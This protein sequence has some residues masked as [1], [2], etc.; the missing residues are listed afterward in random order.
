M[1]EAILKVEIVETR[2]VVLSLT[3]TEAAHLYAQLG[4]STD[5]WNNPEASKIRKEIRSQLALATG[6]W[7][8]QHSSRGTKIKEVK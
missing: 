2:T 6:K 7:E 4:W 5:P 8:F 1:A 3:E